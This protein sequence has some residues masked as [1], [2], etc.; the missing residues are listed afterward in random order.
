MQRWEAQ[1]LLFASIDSIDK[2]IQGLVFLPKRNEIFLKKIFG[3]KVTDNIEKA[4][5]ARLEIKVF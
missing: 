2:K 4:V 3:N 1:E 5:R